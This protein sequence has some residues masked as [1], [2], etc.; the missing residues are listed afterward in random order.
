MAMRL[1]AT[2][3]RVLH[4]RA[5]PPA[6]KCELFRAMLAVLGGEIERAWARD[7]FVYARGCLDLRQAVCRA[8]EEFRR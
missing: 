2:G 4:D 6:A 5:L 8:Y 1:T 3:R 7:D